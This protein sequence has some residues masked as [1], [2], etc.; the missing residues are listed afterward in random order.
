MTTARRATPCTSLFALGLLTGACKDDAPPP[1]AAP[2][3]ETGRVEA[4]AADAPADAGKSAAVPLAQSTA[5]APGKAKSAGQLGFDLEALS[6]LYAIEGTPLAATWGAAGTG[7]PSSMRD[8]DLGTAWR[9]PIPAAATPSASPHCVAGLSFAE[10]ATVHSVRLFAAAGPKWNDYRA[11]PRPKRVRL[12][13]DAGWFDV[14]LDDGSAHHYINL[15]APVTTRTLAVEVLELYA[16]KKKPE[17]WFAELE[18]F[19]SAGPP[20]PPLQL[21]PSRV[22]ISF[23]TEAWKAEGTNN[24]IRIAFAEELAADSGARRRL[25]RATAIHGDADD[26]FLV[27]ER[28]FGTDCTTDR[29][30]YLL[31]DRDTRVPFPLG[32]KG[33]V[34]ASVTLRA[35]G[36]GVMFV[37]DAEPEHARALVYEGDQL[38]RHQPKT[39]AGETAKQL[40]ARLGFVGAPV[41]RGGVEPGVATGTCVAGTTDEALVGRIGTALDVLNLHGAQASICPL[42]DGSKAVVGTDGAA[43]GPRWY[44]AV[45]AP[46]G[47]IIAQNLAGEGDGDGAHFMAVAELGVVLEGTR[48]GGATSDLWLLDA[49]GISML[50]KGG[51]LAVRDPKAC[52]PCAPATPVLDETTTG[53]DDDG[54]GDGGPPADAAPADAPS[55]TPPADAPPSDAPPADAPPPSDPPAK[56]EPGDA[57]ALPGVNDEPE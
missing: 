32:D 1:T 29:G 39:K 22:V 23:E 19:G 15:A 56:A 41:G 5:A 45:V 53:G 43:C 18:A 2:R 3:V 20:R 27:V 37:R 12:H 48:A 9:C 42:A 35:D 38:V 47:E 57:P 28:R 33:E 26:R 7:E 30:S 55:D 49:K 54:A 16:G 34:P 6:N 46:S 13:T 21:D 44:A 52:R 40:A 17:L 36:L 4:K 51:A 10:P 31:L 14:G 11:H 50:V 25:M 8:D 24:T